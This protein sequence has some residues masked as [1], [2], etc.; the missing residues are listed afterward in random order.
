M[1]TKSIEG[2]ASTTGSGDR[3]LDDDSTTGK[4]SLEYPGRY[5]SFSQI[6]AVNNFIWIN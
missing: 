6:D 4:K 5:L 2:I 3:G 1:K